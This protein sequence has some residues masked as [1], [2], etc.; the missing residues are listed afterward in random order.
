M[1]RAA[2]RGRAHVWVRPTILRRLLR[3]LWRI[4]RTFLLLGAALAPGMPPPPPPSPHPT[5]QHDAE[6]GAL[7][8]Q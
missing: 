8:E 2:R 4:L 6:G 3:F 5:E 1:S 7:D